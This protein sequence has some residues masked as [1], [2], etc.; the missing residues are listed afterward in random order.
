M[1]SRMTVDSEI[2]NEQ[3]LNLMYGILIS[4]GGSAISNLVRN[5]ITYLGMSHVRYLS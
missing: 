2:K 3:Q 4:L 1:L 5:P